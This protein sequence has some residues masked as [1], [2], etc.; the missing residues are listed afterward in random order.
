MKKPINSILLF[1]LIAGLAACSGSA[2][3]HTTYDVFTTEFLFSPSEFIVPAGQEITLNLSNN[4]AV[5][6]DFI[7]LK[8][9]AD[10]GDH[11]DEEDRANIYW[12]VEV[13]P[14]E[15]V[16]TTFTAPTEAGEYKVVCGIQGHLEAEAPSRA[17][18]G[19]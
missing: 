12:D 8:L 17:I 19:T 1:F 16:T 9:G 3:P 18:F 11:F 13:Q 10:V 6:H 4:G 15:S 2:K 7:I 5:V 14:G